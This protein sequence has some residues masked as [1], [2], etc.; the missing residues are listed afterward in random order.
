MRARAGRMKGI[1]LRPACGRRVPALM[2]AASPRDLRRTLSTPS[3]NTGKVPVFGETLS[4][5]RGSDR[6]H[7]SSIPSMRP[8]TARRNRTS[9][10]PIPAFSGCT[11]PSR[12]AFEAD[13]KGSAIPSCFEPSS[14]SPPF[15]KESA[16]REDHDDQGAG[17]MLRGENNWCK[18]TA[19]D[20]LEAVDYSL[21]TQ[22]PVGSICSRT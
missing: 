11:A 4:G 14:G 2:R 12:P 1:A 6:I 8:S 19:G 22:P 15:G 10:R 3:P 18:Q 13:W 17:L 16:G 21:G 5:L 9:W 7:I 20:H